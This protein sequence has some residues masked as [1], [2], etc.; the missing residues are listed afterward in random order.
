MGDRKRLFEFDLDAKP[1]RPDWV[2]GTFG[3]LPTGVIIALATP[4]ALA[5]ALALVAAAIGLLPWH[6]L[7]FGVLF[8]SLYLFVLSQLAR[9]L[10]T[11]ETDSCRPI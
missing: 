11:V 8:F 3:D 9:E 2:T 10:E 6:V 5:A 7:I 4:P 1:E